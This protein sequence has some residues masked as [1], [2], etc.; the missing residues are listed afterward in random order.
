MRKQAALLSAVWAATLL[1]CPT[2]LAQDRPVPR[3]EK[4][5]CVTDVLKAAEAECHTFFTYENRD[6][7]SGPV[8]E[9]PV[10]VI[11]KSDHPDVRSVFYFPGGPGASPMGRE[12]VV[13]NL[14]KAAGDHPLVLVDS[15]GMVHSKPA[16]AC[17]VFEIISHY[18]NM[19]TD[20]TLGGRTPADRMKL[21]A[22]GVRACHDKL[23]GEG[24]DV[25][26][27][28]EYEVARDTNEIR[29]LLGYEK[30]D[31]IGTS[32]GGGTA[33]SYLRYFPESVGA[34]VF[35]WPW[36]SELRNRPLLDE[37]YTTKQIYLDTLSICV[38]ESEECR[39]ALS[40]DWMH[41]IEAVKNALDEKPFEV[42]VRTDKGED[43]RLVFDGVTFIH[44]LYLVLADKY[45][46][47]P[48]VVAD[49]RQ[50]NYEILNQFFDTAG[51]SSFS[52]NPAWALGYYLSHV[53]GDM[54]K[55]RPS[56]EMTTRMLE[57]EPAL[58][59]FEPTVLCA[60]W[61][62]D[63]AVPPQH[64]DPVKFDGPA[65]SLHGQM[66]PC[67]SIRWGHQLK[68][69]MPKLQSVVFPGEGHGWAIECRAEIINAFLK[70]PD[71]EVDDSC[72]T[73]KPL[74]P[75]VLK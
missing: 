21:Y 43:R 72:A 23:V 15:R 24:V 3:L 32:T 12:A 27:Y 22:D 33:N 71:E 38:S 52:S 6:A 54:G 44:H 19:F 34:A 18:H 55:N 37:Y 74:K 69:N 17:P 41:S 50:G 49:V 13:T 36:F 26:R 68:R 59:G 5:E 1:S 46:I 64:S 40:D 62:T 14:R 7:K 67:C 53:C 35:A 39:A 31:I 30:V 29:E 48:K 9:L 4:S 42:T 65:L 16:L 63:G 47:L 10:A 75:W 60:W 57:A 25:S 70:S 20:V 51:A 8:L 66:D 11:G 58:I 45:D 56:V 73:S 28:N 2:A 61:G